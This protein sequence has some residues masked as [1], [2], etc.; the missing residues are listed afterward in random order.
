MPHIFQTIVHPTDFSEI[1]VEAFV[2]ALRI[3]L[4]MRSKLYLVHIA[5]SGYPDE[6]DGFPHVRH[7]LEQWHLSNA[8]ETP[9]AVSQKLGIKVAKI[10][11]E[12]QDPLRGLLHFL[13]QHPS[14]LIVL[15]T[16][17][18]DG[19]A[20]WLQGSIAEK[21]SRTAG[22]PTLFVPP[23]ACGFVEQSNAELHLSRVLVP[24]DHSPPASEALGTI[25]EFIGLMN[26]QGATIELMHVGETAPPIRRVADGTPVHV[27]MRTGD[28]VSA[29]RS[30]FCSSAAFRIRLPATMAFLMRCAEAPRSACCGMHLAPCWRFQP[31]DPKVCRLRASWSHDRLIKIAPAWATGPKNGSRAGFG[32]RG[33][34]D[35]CHERFDGKT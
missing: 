24:V 12:P 35:A 21:L 16:H 32:D 3:A 7:A 8:N 34:N 19:I 26:E 9:A 33:H 25:H 23:T 28:V 14:D 31:N 11:L 20:H 13:E 4:V 2:H 22:L 15:A 27:T 1:S 5:E 18:R 17:G 6:Q 29:I 10:G 30:A